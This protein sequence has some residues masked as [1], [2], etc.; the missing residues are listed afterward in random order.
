MRKRR[1]TPWGKPKRIRKLVKFRV[2][3]YIGISQP[4][5]GG[6]PSFEEI[7]DFW[8]TLLRDNKCVIFWSSE[9]LSGHLEN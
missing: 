9:A 5:K 2:E 4:K 3:L 8:A 1:K 6:E 7:L